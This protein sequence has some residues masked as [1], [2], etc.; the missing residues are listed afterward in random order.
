[1]IKNESLI[2]FAGM[3]LV[4]YLPRLLPLLAF[5]GRR[6]PGWFIDWLELIPASIL[7]ALL[8]PSL[9]TGG[10]PPRLQWR[11]EL[12]VAI[13]VF[14]FAWRTKSL[15]GTVLLGMLLF[16]LINSVM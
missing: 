1:M 16:W 11:P 14:I 7:S 9:F 4:T 5:S 2:L 12:V 8:A 10:S 6:L 15:A 13:P 3:G